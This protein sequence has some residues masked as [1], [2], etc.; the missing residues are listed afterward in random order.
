ME[1]TAWPA[2]ALATLTRL[3][4]EGKSGSEI[5]RA[6]YEQ[7]GL[8]KSRNAVIGVVHRARL[9]K[10]SIATT[11][12]AQRRANGSASATKRQRRFNPGPKSKV[13]PMPE[14]KPHAAEPE[15]RAVPLAMLGAFECHWVTD[16][17][18]FEQRYCGHPVVLGAKYCPHHEQRSRVPAVKKGRAR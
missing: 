18:R 12:R 3:W 11:S 7:H 17:T 2:P 15:S 16:P 10:R 8:R 5:A 13:K 14:P 1:S 9:P 4:G 6:V